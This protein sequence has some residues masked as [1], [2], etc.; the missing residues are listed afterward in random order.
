MDTSS[1]ISHPAFLFTSQ[2]GKEAM[3][4]E[5]THHGTMDKQQICVST[6]IFCVVRKKWPYPP[7]TS[8]SYNR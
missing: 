7:T 3:K 5:R 4:D 2:R 6:S 1:A 8:G